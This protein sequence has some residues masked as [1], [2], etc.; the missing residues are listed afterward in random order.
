MASKRKAVQ[1]LWLKNQGRSDSAALLVEQL[2]C[3]GVLT[4][5]RE[6]ESHFV[7]KLYEPFDVEAGGAWA[8]QSAD[9]M[10]SFGINAVVVRADSKDEVTAAQEAHYSPW[11]F[12]GSSRRKGVIMLNLMLSHEELEQMFKNS[13]WHTDGDYLEFL[14]QVAG[15]VAN[16]LDRVDM[17]AAN[18]WVKA[19]VRAIREGL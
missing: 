5:V 10:Q 12:R 17:D 3:A 18:F 9:R 19:C 14:G 15:N 7:L 11:L 13:D 16:Y 1:F 2:R 4:I 6:T 8:Q